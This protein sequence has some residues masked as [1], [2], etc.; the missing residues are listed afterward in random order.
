LT[1]W[2]DDVKLGPVVRDLVSNSLRFTP[3]D[4]TIQVTTTQIPD[5]LPKAAPKFYLVIPMVAA[6]ETNPTTAVNI[7]APV[8]FKSK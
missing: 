8:T 2:G 3:Q 6:Q 1:V 7:H 4:G 5:G